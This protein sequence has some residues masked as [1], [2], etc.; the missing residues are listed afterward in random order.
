LAWS[1][2]RLPFTRKV[3]T[4]KATSKVIGAAKGE[5][6]HLTLAFIASDL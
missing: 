2:L 5:F 4:N 3:G 6:R 1:L